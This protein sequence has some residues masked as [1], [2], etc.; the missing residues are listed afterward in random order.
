MKKT[1]ITPAIEPVCLDTECYLLDYSTGFTDDP[2]NGA[3]N[4]REGLFYEDEEL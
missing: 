2:A 4:A 1:Y 3:A